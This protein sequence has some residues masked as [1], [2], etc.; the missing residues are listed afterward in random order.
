M[1]YA[2]GGRETTAAL[3]ALPTARGKAPTR[4]DAA[5]M[6]AFAGLLA[7][8]V[9]VRAPKRNGP[10]SRVG[11]A[12]APVTPNCLRLGPSARP[13]SA[14]LPDPATTRPT[15]IILAPFPT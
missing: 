2:P 15:T 14:S 6:S 5:E 3:S 9:F 7:H 1:V 4:E 13:S 12:R 10:I 11:W 8:A